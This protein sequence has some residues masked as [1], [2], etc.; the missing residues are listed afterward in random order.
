MT[1]LFGTI[2][3]DPP[4]KSQAGGGRYKRGADRH[5]PLM[6]TRDIAALHIPAA[7]D[8]CLFLWS[9]WNDVPNALLVMQAWGFRYT[10]GTPWIKLTV[11]GRGP[12]MGLGQ[13]LRGCSEPLLLGIRGDIERLGGAAPLGLL[14]DPIFAPRLQHSRKPD[15]VYGLA[16]FFPGPYLELFARRPR[17]GWSVW[18][19]EVDHSI[20]LGSVAGE[21]K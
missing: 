18:G 11:D 12:S 4:W 15:D 17:D 9:T 20:Q 16:A 14:T 21:S 5:Y 7:A 6:A 8:A 3:A 13:Y 19:N 2:V 10:T 1:V